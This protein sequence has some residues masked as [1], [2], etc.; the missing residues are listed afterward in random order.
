M[1]EAETLQRAALAE[2]VGEKKSLLERFE[3]LACACRVNAADHFSGLSS[4]AT[5]GNPHYRAHHT[6]GAIA[7][8]TT[9]EMV[10]LS[11]REAGMQPM[12][13]AVLVVFRRLLG[14]IRNNGGAAEDRCK[15]F[16]CHPDEY[17]R[18]EDMARAKCYGDAER[19]CVVALESAEVAA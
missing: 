3:L 16:G 4:A 11:L 15:S 14:A 12:A 17:T 19:L 2:L 8:L 1:S 5:R 10:E 18:A 13:S 7:W 9:G 6:G